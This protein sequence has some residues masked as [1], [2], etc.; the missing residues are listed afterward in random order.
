MEVEGL[1]IEVKPQACI[2]ILGA[3]LPK[4]KRPHP[5]NWNG[6]LHCREAL[7]GGWKGSSANV[8]GP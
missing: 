5:A 7:S 4:L 1:R 8:Q 3:Y 2:W 6:H